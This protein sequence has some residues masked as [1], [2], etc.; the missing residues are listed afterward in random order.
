MF[1]LRALTPQYKV[2]IIMRTVRLLSFDKLK[3]LP[4]QV[5]PLIF[6]IVYIAF[7]T[8]NST[9]DA[10]G[11]AGHIKYGE[12]LFQ[13]HH[14][15]YSFLGFIGYNIFVLLGFSS[16]VLAFLKVFNALSAS[17]SLMLLGYILMLLFNNKAKTLSWIFFAGSTWGVM[18]FAT[19][20]ETYLFPIM[21]SLAGSFFFLKFT[22]NQKV[23]FLFLSG[24]FAALACLFHQIHFFWWVA[25]PIGLLLQ[26]QVKNAILFTIPALIVP[27]A[28]ILA[29]FVYYNNPIEPNSLLQFVFRDFY[30]G[31]ANVATGLTSFMFTAMSLFRTFLQVHG[32]IFVLIKAQPI[33]ILGFALSL[34]LFVVTLFFVKTIKFSFKIKT[35]AFLI[36]HIIAFILQFIF[37]FLSSGNAEFM[38]MLPFLMALTLPFFLSSETSVV[39]YIA[40][41]ML[42]WNITLGLIPL[43]NKILDSSKM[44]VSKVTGTD[45]CKT[46][47]VVFNKPLI[48]NIVK[49]QTK[50][51]PSNVVSGIN[52][53]DVKEIKI[54]IEASLNAGKAVYTDCLSRPNTLSRESI[55]TDTRNDIFEGYTLVKVDSLETISG[56][57]YLTQVKR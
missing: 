8:N 30:S 50:R 2:S 23:K 53:V 20:N 29:T 4:F 24:S 27:I 52:K 17:I 15:L 48:E 6:F 43:N 25:L 44:V 12:S 26:R 45:Q 14:L 51:M 16:D 11:Y 34:V 41:G 39:S 33:Y 37:A 18:R 1:T 21:F 36:P 7:P 19:E 35:T 55:L 57:Y 40:S 9:V 38:V 56:K 49:Y 13:S 42:I 32:Y 46:F 47:F 3:A 54:I 28:Y 5:L 10:Y 31:H 22:S